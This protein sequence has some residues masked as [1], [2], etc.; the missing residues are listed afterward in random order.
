MD[1]RALPESERRT[2][3]P[4]SQGLADAIWGLWPL[5]SWGMPVLIV[6]FPAISPPGGGWH[7]LVLL[8]LSPVIVGG[9]GLLGSLPRMLLRRAGH[10]SAPAG[11]LWLLILHWWSWIPIILT[12]RDVTDGPVPSLLTHMLPVGLSHESQDTLQMVALAVLIFSWAAILVSA[13]SKRPPRQVRLGLAAG[14]AAV[15]AAPALAALGVVIAAADSASQQDAAGDRPTVV[16]QLSTDEQRERYESRYLE[17]QESVVPVRE[18]VSAEDWE[19][20]ARLDGYDAERSPTGFDI[21][22]LSLHFSKDISLD[23]EVLEQVHEALTGSGWEPAASFVEPATDYEHAN[24]AELRINDSGERFALRV[25]SPQWWSDPQ[26]LR[27]LRRTTSREHLKRWKRPSPNWRARRA[28]RSR[29][30]TMTSGQMLP[31]LRGTDCAASRDAR[32][33][34]L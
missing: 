24:G 18:A 8:L 34:R 2:D 3:T 9:A 21:Y 7:A 5:M 1:E 11:M 19:A 15:A 28:R 17:L 13:A 31:D 16:R 29:S 10:T 6:F 32:S 33:P 20:T 26:A 12:F 30:T 22:Y 23:D 27:N 4:R 25:T 14:Y